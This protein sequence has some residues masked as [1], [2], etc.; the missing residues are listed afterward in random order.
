MKLSRSEKRKRNFALIKNKYADIDIARQARDWSDKRIYSE[1]GIKVTKKTPD[2][3][4]YDAKTTRRKQRELKNFWYAREIGHSPQRAKQLKSY[5]HRK[6]DS[7]FQYERTIKRK[8]TKG[9]KEKRKELWKSWSSLTHSNTGHFKRGNDNMP[10]EIRREAVK[11]NREQGFD[12]Y[13]QYG[14][15]FMFFWFIENDRAKASQ[16]ISPQYGH[17]E[18]YKYQET[19]R[20]TTT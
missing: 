17:M 4:Q 15:A 10:P 18:T 6:I 8:Y 7:S 20:V 1:L 5:S 16:I 12:D 13:D 3:K 19:I 14:F 2:L 11:L 9:S